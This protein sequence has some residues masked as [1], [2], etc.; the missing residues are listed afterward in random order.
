MPTDLQITMWQFLHQHCRKGALLVTIP[1]VEKSLE[2]LEVGNEV[3][4]TRETANRMDMGLAQFCQYSIRELTNL[5]F[6]NCVYSS[7]KNL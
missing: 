1:S 4:G 5:A 2:L 7:W 3:Q 6:V